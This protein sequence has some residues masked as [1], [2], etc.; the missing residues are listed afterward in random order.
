MSEL[1]AEMNKP[2]NEDVLIGLEKELSQLVTEQKSRNQ[3]VVK[4]TR[5][6]KMAKDKL[7]A[8]LWQQSKKSGV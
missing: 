7:D 1:E 2:T 5:I 3:D 8:Y 4:R 6:W